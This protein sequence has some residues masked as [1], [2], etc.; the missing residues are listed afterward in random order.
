MH[1]THTPR[2]EKVLLVLNHD[3]NRGLNSSKGSLIS[4]GVILF[5]DA[6]LNKFKGAV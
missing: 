2:L 5:C 3:C 4:D 6:I 1:E